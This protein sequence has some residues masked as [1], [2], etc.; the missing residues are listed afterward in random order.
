MPVKN[1]SEFDS[2]KKS[3]KVISPSA[4]ERAIAAKKKTAND[5]K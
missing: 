3:F 4:K 2:T 5:Q 1:Q